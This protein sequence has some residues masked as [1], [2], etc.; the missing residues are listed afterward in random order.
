MITYYMFDAKVYIKED[1]K[2]FSE[3]LCEY[4]STIDGNVIKSVANDMISFENM[5][6]DSTIAISS[7]IRI[8][9]Q[10]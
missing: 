6:N 3:D 4:L 7:Y 2:H 5:W 8:F 9:N 10:N 1:I